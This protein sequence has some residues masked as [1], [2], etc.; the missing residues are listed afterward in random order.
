MHINKF[1][2]QIKLNQFLKESKDCRKHLKEGQKNRNNNYRHHLA[3]TDHSNLQNPNLLRSDIFY[4]IGDFIITLF[5]KLN[6]TI[7]YL[8]NRLILL[9]D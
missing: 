6:W 3:L 9:V 5:Y 7:N 1:K 4:L 8:S 2:N